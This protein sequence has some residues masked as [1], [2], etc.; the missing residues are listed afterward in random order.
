MIWTMI[1]LNIIFHPI[2]LVV[3][4]NIECL[5]IQEEEEEENLFNS[6]QKYTMM[7]HMQNEHYSVRRH[8]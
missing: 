5:F 7:I 8:P 2:D 6:P 3:I 1:M 4:L